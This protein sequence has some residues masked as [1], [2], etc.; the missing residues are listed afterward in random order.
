MSQE[1]S[2]GGDGAKGK[3]LTAKEKAQA[4]LQDRIKREANKA[5]VEDDNCLTLRTTS[6]T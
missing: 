3:E 4:V 5:I 6:G 2:E 1:L